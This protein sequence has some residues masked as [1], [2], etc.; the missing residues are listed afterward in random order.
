MTFLLANGKNLSSDG[1][2]IGGREIA[3]DQEKPHP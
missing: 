3:E 2:N 1:F